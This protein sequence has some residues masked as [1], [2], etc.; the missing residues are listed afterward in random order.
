MRTHRLGLASGTALVALFA[1]CATIINGT[2]QKIGISSE[3]TGVLVTVDSQP[4]GN[5]P[6][7]V[8]LTRKDTHIIRVEKDGYRPHETCLTRH[9]SGWVWGNI[10]FGGVIGL[11]VDACTGGLYKLDPNQVTANLAPASLSAAVGDSP[12]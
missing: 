3:P 9:A 11:V 4:R 5:T 8:E 12:R 1:G 6:V 7:F 2:S 10:V